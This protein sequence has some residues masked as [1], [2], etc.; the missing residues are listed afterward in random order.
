MTRAL[1]ARWPDPIELAG[2]V[3][4]RDRS[5][6]AA[7]L[8]LIDDRRLAA[9]QRAAALTGR[10][11]ALAG[12]QMVVG[13]HV[14]GVTGPP[15]SGK[16]SLTSKLIGIWRHE[17]RAVGV[18]AVDPSSPRTG[19]ALL[20]D[21]I[22][23]LRPATDE[24]VFIRSLASRGE[25][26]GLCAEV[27][28]MSIVLLA[29]FDVVVVETVGVGQS[30]VDVT[31]LA[32]TTC[33][34]IQPA[35]GDTVQFLKAGIMEVPDVFAVSKADLGH[36]AERTAREL[37]SAIPRV[38][39]AAWDAPVVLV[40][41]STGAGVRELAGALDAHRASLGDATRL[42]HRRKA[43]Q[44]RFVLRRLREEFGSH[45]VALLGGS[46]AIEADLARGNTPPLARYG[47]LRNRG[48]SL[49]GSGGD[50]REEGSVRSR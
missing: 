26:G 29:A 2:A 46:D 4:R 9:R 39:G 42:E 35:S 41:A 36:A 43:R 13:G 3:V 11:A 37:A 25:L 33:C 22:R 49:F 48:A 44:A 18:L 21:R 50:G 10:L 6:V 7:A 8:N 32:D 24:D 20:G 40:S 28:P 12:G 5:A 30:E 34:V 19:G 15:G 16:S 1:E 45:G 17:R 27:W 14:I 31:G 47:E 38:S 23:M